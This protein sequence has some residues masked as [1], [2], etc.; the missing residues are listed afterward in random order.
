MIVNR[1]SG[2]LWIALGLFCLIFF[3]GRLF[4]QLI[5]VLVGFSLVV[6]GLKILAIDR[7]MYNYSMHYFNDQ[8]KK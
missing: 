4:F 3:G 8:F 5:G 1:V 2:Y 7:A 6:K